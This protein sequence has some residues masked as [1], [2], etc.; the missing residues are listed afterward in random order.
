MITTNEWHRIETQ[1]CEYKHE[2]Q[3][4]NHDLADKLFAVFHHEYEELTKRMCDFDACE[5]RYQTTKWY[6]VDKF[7]KY[8]SDIGFALRAYEVQ[9]DVVDNCVDALKAAAVAIE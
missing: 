7:G 5:N 9:K 8:E 6:R 4:T 1:A 3:K 2:I